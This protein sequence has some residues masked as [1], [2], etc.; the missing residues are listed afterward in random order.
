MDKVCGARSCR[1]IRNTGKQERNKK[2][3]L[4]SF[5]N[6]LCAMR[7]LL[8]ATRNPHKTAE[9]AEIL[10]DQFVVRDL[11]EESE[12]SVIQET[13]AT[14]EENAILKA[15]EASQHFADDVVGDDSGLEVDALS[16]APGV[17]SARY[18][19]EGATDAENV[20]KILGQLMNSDA[21]SHAARFR[22][23]LVL[24]RRGKVLGIFE[25]AVEG[26]IVPVP[27]GAAGF[28]YDPI[29]QPLGC[30]RTF[31][32]LSASDKNK[33]SHRARAIGSLR[34]ALI[35]ET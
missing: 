17:F 12:L 15:V 18:A 1:R 35:A 27:R 13:G 5:P 2:I 22:C 11:S 24:A 28:G 7:H 34:A 6:S 21:P 16:G 32:E 10:G 3:L 29:F 19:G 33:M 14:F 31:G 23:V 4:S 25:G 30:N 8:L 9:F 26:S 20:A